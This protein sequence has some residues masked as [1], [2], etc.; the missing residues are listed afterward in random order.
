MALV[1]DMLMESDAKIASL[2][3]KSGH[4]EIHVADATRGVGIITARNQASA[5]RP[6]L[7]IGL[8][9]NLTL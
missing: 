6:I 7:A 5:T 4:T 3:G 8:T 9:R 1:R 2:V